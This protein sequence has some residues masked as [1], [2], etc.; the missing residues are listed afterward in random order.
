MTNSEGFSPQTSCIGCS[1][2]TALIQPGEGPFS[3]AA[4]DDKSPRRTMPSYA[5]QGRGLSSRKPQG[6]HVTG[7]GRGKDPP[8]VCPNLLWNPLRIP[9]VCLAEFNVSQFLSRPLLLRGPLVQDQLHKISSS[10]YRL[11]TKHFKTKKKSVR[12]NH[13]HAHTL[14]PP[15]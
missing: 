12:N 3:N 4:S 10:P 5:W 7:V 13:T 1:R 11:T 9:T 2:F 15:N 8:R 6:V 14:T